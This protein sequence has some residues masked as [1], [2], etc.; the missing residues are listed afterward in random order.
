MGAVDELNKYPL[1]IGQRW[2]LWSETVLPGEGAVVARL[3]LEGSAASPL[4]RVMKVRLGRYRRPFDVEREADW[5][6]ASVDSQT[7]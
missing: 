3:A 2:G 1:S 5:I 6:A 4:A 7:C